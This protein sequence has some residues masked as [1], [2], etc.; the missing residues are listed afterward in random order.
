M[1]TKVIVV[2][3]EKVI[4][5]FTSEISLICLG[6]DGIEL[7]R[8]SMWLANDCTSAWITVAGV[9]EEVPDEPFSEFLKKKVEQLTRYEYEVVAIYEI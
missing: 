6:E 1:K 7:R 5:D 9:D 8:L 4:T 2:F 3:A